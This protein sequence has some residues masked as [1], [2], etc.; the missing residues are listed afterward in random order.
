[1]SL[2][3]IERAR[4]NKCSIYAQLNESLIGFTSCGNYSKYRSF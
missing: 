2:D 1:M 4:L 3:I